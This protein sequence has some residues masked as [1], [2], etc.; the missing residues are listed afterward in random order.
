MKLG[1]RLATKLA[2]AGRFAL[3]QLERAGATAGVALGVADHASAR[4]RLRGACSRPLVERATRAFDEFD[5]APA[6]QATEETF[7][8]FCDNYLEIVKVR[9]YAEAPS[10]RARVRARDA[11]ARAARLP[12]AVRARASVRDRRGLVVALRRRRTRALDPHQPLADVERSSPASTCSRAGRAYDAAREVSAAIRGAKTG[13]KKSLRWPVARL[14]VRGADAELAALRSVLAD[15]LD[16]GSVDATACRLE[17]GAPAEGAL[18]ATTIE[19]AEQAA[20][21][22]S[23]SDVLAGAREHVSPPASGAGGRASCRRARPC[24]RTAS[25]RTIGD[26]RARVRELGSALGVNA[27]WMIGT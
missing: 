6:L 24:R 19:L 9:A 20:G 22:A 17:V 15:V 4:R 23:A 7:W 25:R 21:P 12:A 3:L 13:A 26:H 16:A 10:P 2:N 18:F 14:E 8:D 5:F 11:A 1:R 27:A